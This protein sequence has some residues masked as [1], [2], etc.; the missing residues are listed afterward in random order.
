MNGDGSGLEQMTRHIGGFGAALPGGS[1]RMEK[2]LPS[3]LI[4]TWCREATGF[5]NFEIYAIKL[6]P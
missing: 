6:A 3:N 2:R 1:A 4:A 5:L